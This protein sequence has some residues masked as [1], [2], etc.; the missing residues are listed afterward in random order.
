[1]I[2]IAVAP[3]TPRA[4]LLPLVGTKALKVPRVL[5]MRPGTTVI[6]AALLGIGA[7]S[8]G[9]EL[10]YP[11]LSVVK[12]SLPNG[13]Q[14]LLHE[15]HSS[16][17]VAVYLWYRVGRADQAVGESGLAHLF[18]HL[19]VLAGTKH[20]N[21]QQSETLIWSMG[22]GQDG[23]TPGFA[24]TYY[25]FGR[26]NYLETM[27]WLH[28]DR[29]GFLEAALTE[30]AVR[31]QIRVIKNERSQIIDNRPFGRADQL[32]RDL[33]FPKPHP[34]HGSIFGSDEDLDR[35]TVDRLTRF[36]RAHYGPANVALVIDG[37][38]E[39]DVA[40][41]L[42]AQYFGTLKGPGQLPATPP[43]AQPPPAQLRQTISANIQSPRLTFAWL[44]MPNMAEGSVE[45][46]LVASLLGDGKAALLH[47]ELVRR[48][49]LAES[50]S[51]SRP[52]DLLGSIFKCD[53]TAAPGAEIGKLEAGFLRSLSRIAQVG[54]TPVDLNRAKARL[55]SGLLHRTE[56]L[57]SRAILINYYNHFVGRPDYLG[58]HLQ[59]LAATSPESI[60]KTVKAYLDPGHAVVVLARPRGE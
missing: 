1:M 38:F 32:V 23:A 41:R 33:L 22:G 12:Y 56:N 19:M 10:R 14:V 7:S 43:M 44:A 16:P 31:S 35:V 25:T 13:L 21:V 52:T 57:V 51:C 36:F 45:L 46:D 60:R 15:E 6:L 34:N 49:T 59:V 11:E 39:P 26:A 24:T 40:R 27:L 5:Y 53:L 54:P 48:E 58:T 29:M 30:E 9:A 17:L 2:Q 37:D 47:Q 4:R 8:S 18:E 3:M 42:V 50:V 20:I 28:S 55:K